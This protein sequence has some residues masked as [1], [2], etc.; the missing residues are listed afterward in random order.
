MPVG[1]I[2][3]PHCGQPHPL[4]TSICPTSARSLERGV[5]AAKR[6]EHRLIG[7]TVA[8]KYAIRRL[9]GQGGMGTVF[10]AE[11]LM[12]RR[13]VALKVVNGT[14]SADARERLQREAIIVASVQH[15][16]I[17][18][19]YDF[20]MMPDETPYMVMER[21]FGETL[22]QL[23]RR[24]RD[25]PLSSVV[26]IFAQIL[27]GL[28]A[29]H[30]SHI[31]HRDLKP[32]NVFLVDRL[33]LT[34][35][36]KIVDFGFAKDVSGARTRT[37]TKPG[38]MLGTVQYMSPEQLRCDPID[39]RADIFAVGLMLYEALAGQHPYPIEHVMELQ[40]RILLE[41]PPPPSSLRSGLP[42]TFDAI[43]MRALAKEPSARWQNSR[44]MQRALLGALGPTTP[45]NP[46]PL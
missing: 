10:E 24:R 2:W 35:L 19:L 31:V 16:N 44:E 43:V 4:G 18:D 39:A 14:A 38:K 12:L 5:H 11:N 1:I 17:C 33:G 21:L 40:R 36:V 23:M 45:S 3:C 6:S 26:D 28:Q 9:I 7:T 27:S 37:I 32:A 25:L 20:G 29:A 30:G 42:P 34:P 15:P 46:P 22:M 8:G 13:M 41:L